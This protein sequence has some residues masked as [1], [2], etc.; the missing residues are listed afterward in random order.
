M[1][2]IGVVFCAGKGVGGEWGGTTEAEFCIEK[3]PNKRPV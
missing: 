3:R 2:S 1:A